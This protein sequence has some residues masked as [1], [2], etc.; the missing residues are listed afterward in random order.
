MLVTRFLHCTP[1]HFADKQR[2]E[3]FFQQNDKNLHNENDHKN[4]Y[5]LPAKFRISDV[6][7]ISWLNNLVFYA[8]K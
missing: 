5:P 3:F 2:A 7:F 1:A 4:P 6:F 8:P